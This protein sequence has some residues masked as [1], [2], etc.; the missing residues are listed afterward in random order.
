[1]LYWQITEY[2]SSESVNEVFEAAARLAPMVLVIEDIDSM[3]QEVRSFFLNTLDGATS[4][5]GSS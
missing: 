4:K 3:P 2:T 5:E 1:M